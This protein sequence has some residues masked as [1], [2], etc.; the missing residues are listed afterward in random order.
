[1]RANGREFHRATWAWMLIL[2]AAG[3]LQAQQPAP[4]GEAAARVNGEVIT[5]TELEREV[6]LE[7]QK[8][9]QKGEEV[10]Q[11]ARAQ[12]EVEALD[13]LIDRLLLLQDSL[14]RGY[15]VEPAEVDQEMASF[16]SQFSDEETFLD[17]LAQF[18]HSPESFRRDIERGMTVQKMIDAEVA[19]GVQVG[20][21]EIQAFYRD[22]PGLFMQ[23]EQVHVRHILIEVVA[24]A[25]EPGRQEA[26]RKIR[27][28]QA[29][30]AGG[31]DFAELARQHSQDPSSEQGGDIG[32]IR[33]GQTLDAFDAAA[34]GL[35][36]GEV[37][38]I[39]SS[40]VGFHLIQVLERR[41]AAPLPLA[42]AHD[43]IG[44]YLKQGRL[45]AAVSLRLDGLRA[46]ASIETE[47]PGGTPG[48]AA[49][50][51]LERGRARAAVPALTPVSR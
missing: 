43:S 7:V 47:L 14:R 32:F 5:A 20:E 44:E 3:P 1:M 18:K 37:S 30:V 17:V 25:G 45:T 40:E 50:D 24:D 39:V 28:L 38:G 33:P 8:R 49:E 42:D 21:E 4:P 51:T 19:P 48:G 10:P 16:R 29:R 31:A 11:A 22:N 23:P 6:L 34:F 41:P 9:K 13:T 2:A 46:V 35:Q 36:P 27:D 26:L 12:L 15:R